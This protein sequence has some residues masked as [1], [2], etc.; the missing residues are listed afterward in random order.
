M[1]DG[2]R[3]RRAASAALLAAVLAACGDSA[4]SDA[5]SMCTSACG[6]HG[7]AH[8]DHCDCNP[9]Y[10]D[11][12][13]CCVP[14]P[15]CTAPDDAFEENDTAE[16]ATPVPAGG[17]SRAGLRV[18]PADQDVFRVPL[19]VGQR[20]EAALRFTQARGDLDVYLYAPGT[21]DF[22]HAR[23]MASAAG[24]VDNESLS[25]VAGAAGDHLLL[26]LGFEAAENAYDLE[27]RV[28]GP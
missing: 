26:V 8:G 20:V 17:L 11:R 28:T 14:P 10:I 24:T 27:V 25:Y 7:R 5:G 19:A 6:P 15:S 2:T 4:S 13:M 9:G 23:P 18:C 22:V 3:Q 12:M 21:T 16:A 1:S